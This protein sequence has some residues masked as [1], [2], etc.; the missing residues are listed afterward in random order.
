MID[1]L[2]TDH[3]VIVADGEPLRFTPGDRLRIL[4]GLPLH[5]KVAVQL[6]PHHTALTGMTVAYCV[7]VEPFADLDDQ[8][9]PPQQP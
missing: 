2:K 5:I 3:P 4:F 8:S 7:G 9:T 1:P 6:N